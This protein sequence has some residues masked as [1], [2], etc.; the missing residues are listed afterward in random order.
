[1]PLD[2]A[3]RIGAETPP[4]PEGPPYACRELQ[5]WAGGAFWMP[6]SD[7]RLEALHDGGPSPSPPMDNLEGLVRA[8]SEHPEWL[9]FLDPSAPNHE[10]KMLERAI[11]LTHWG[12]W[13]PGSG[14]VLDLGGGCG[15]FTA[16]LLDRG[17]DVEVVA[18]DLR[19]LWRTLQHAAGRAGRVDLHWGTGETLPKLQP[20]DLVV[21]AEV[22][23]YCEDPAAILANCNAVLKPGGA[24]LL[25]VEARWGWAAALDAHPGTL[26]ALFSDGIVHVPGDVWVRTYEEQDLRTLLQGFEIELLLPTHYTLSGPF[27]AAAGPMDLKAALT[28]EARL[29]DHP[30]TRPW[31]RAWLAVA[32]KSLEPANY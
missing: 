2:Q 22:L 6:A 30:R 27:E 20:V 8:W 15:R 10:D 29:R 21:A 32:R 18:P 3:T 28:W 19:S 9:D 4:L 11:Y 26:E 23:N 13:L 24:L 5:A 17:L 1:M 25:S 12:P 16:A 7:P 31:N 14:R